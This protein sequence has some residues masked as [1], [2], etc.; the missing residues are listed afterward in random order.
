MACSMCEEELILL[1]A[2]TS[3]GEEDAERIKKLL[4]EGVDWS[5]VIRR[6]AQHGVIP[7][8]YRSLKSISPDT[9]PETVMDRLRGHYLSNLGRNIFL[10]NELTK[11]VDLLDAHRIAA[12][13]FKGPSL[14][15]SVY[16]Y[17]GLRQFNDLDLLIHKEDVLRTMDLLRVHGFHPEYP[18]TRKQETYLL[19]HN[20]HYALR[21]NDLKV[22]VEIHWGLTP[23]YSPFTMD[24][25][26]LWKTSRPILLQGKSIRTFAPED[27]LLT[28]CE[29]GARHRWERLSW[30][31]DIAELINCNKQM[32]WSETLQRAEE[33]GGKRMVSLGLCLA[34]EL[35]RTHLPEHVIDWM[36]TDRVVKDL[37]G[38]VRNLIFQGEGAQ[39]GN[40]EDRIFLFY[41]K[42]MCRVEDKIKCYLKKIFLPWPIDLVLLPPFTILFPLYYLIRPIRL[43]AK[44]KRIL[45]KRFL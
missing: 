18:L 41:L 9:V 25:D 7:L 11:I 26:R 20:Y 15:S 1:C 42:T 10:T 35:F 24:M 3:V 22:I 4:R 32:N 12:I 43:M 6:T 5:S 28:L 21:R 31:C 16:G 38:Q 30:I 29:H 44:Y 8:L 17:L 23:S 27:S 36:Q 37:V 13:L 34:N 39:D 45:L 19:H 40:S 14:A 2:R 33:A